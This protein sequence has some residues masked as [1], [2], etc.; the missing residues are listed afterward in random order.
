[1]LYSLGDRRVELRGG[2][3]FIAPSAVLI[4]RPY[5]C[6]LAAAG[7]EG[8]SR[9]ITILRREFEMAMALTGKTSIAAIDRSVFWE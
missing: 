5:V 1:M 6:G 8:V 2:G 9:V 4:G 3:H 7:P